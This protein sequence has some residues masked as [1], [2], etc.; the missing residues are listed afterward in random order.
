MTNKKFGRVGDSPIIGAGTWADNATCA[1]SS[2]GHGEYFIRSVAAYDVHALMSYRDLSLRDAARMTIHKHLT[3]VAAGESETAGGLIAVDAEGNIALPFNSPG[4]Y[5]AWK[6][7]DGEGV[8]I[9]MGDT[10]VV[11]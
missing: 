3:G 9:F 8:G 10:K 4:M 11:E 1:V 5:R 2:T 7:A 6:D